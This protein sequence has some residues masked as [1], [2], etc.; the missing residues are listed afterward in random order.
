MS[1]PCRTLRP[2]TGFGVHGVAFTLIELLVV[3]AIVALLICLLLPSLAAAREQGKL[4]KC[5]ANM[6]PIVPVMTIYA[7]D[8]C[9]RRAK[10]WTTTSASQ[11]AFGRAAVEAMQECGL[12]CMG[13]AKLAR[14]AYA[15]SSN[16]KAGARKRK[17]RAH[18]SR[19]ERRPVSTI[20]VPVLGPP[21]PMQDPS[22][23]GWNLLFRY[24]RGG[25]A[26][27][28]V[29]VS[30]SV[31]RTLHTNERGMIENAPD[32]W[33][34]DGCPLH[35]HIGRTPVDVFVR[36]DRRGAPRPIDVPGPMARTNRETL[37]KVGGIVLAGLL[38]Y[39]AHDV[40][41][42]LVNH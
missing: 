25:A 18:K 5:L 7:S 6:R 24:E 41:A 13:G 40:Y 11:D 37:L 26:L 27:A 1:M 3:V 12:R 10:D 31:G 19:R 36:L 23:R 2:R 33:V 35:V 17:R 39:A 38:I 16:C 15:G 8:C 28:N 32:D 29:P 22:R 34:W 4:A 9:D 14:D 42:W 20:G 30:N 21:A